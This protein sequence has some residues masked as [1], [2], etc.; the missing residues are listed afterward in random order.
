MRKADT[1]RLVTALKSSGEYRP[2]SYSGR[3][4]YGQRCV[5]VDLEETSDM[6]QLGALLGEELGVDSVPRARI[7]SMGL[8]IVVYWPDCR[9]TDDLRDELSENDDEEN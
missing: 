6:L 4:M 8:G 7:D 2:Y 1:A 3:A 9:V 5:A